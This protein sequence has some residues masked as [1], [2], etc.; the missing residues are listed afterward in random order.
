MDSSPEHWYLA[1]LVVEFNYGG[2]TSPL[3]LNTY[4]IRARSAEE[5]LDKARLE[6]PDD[7]YTN[8][9]GGKVKC[10]FR[11]VNQLLQ[12]PDELEDGTELFWEEVP[13]ATEEEILKLI[14][15]PE[16]MAAFSKPPRHK[17][18]FPFSP[19]EDDT[20]GD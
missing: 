16:E 5:A 11:G 13:E 19:V 14:K 12:L 8:L 20:E 17:K 2:D 10:L 3:Q 4:L 18:E 7:E 6:E 15:K 1:T 9:L